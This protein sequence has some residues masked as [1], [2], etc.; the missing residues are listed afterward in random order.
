MRKNILSFDSFQVNEN[1]Y[2]IDTILD[3]INDS[4][5]DSLDF[6]EKKVLENPDIIKKILYQYNIKLNNI[7]DMLSKFGLDS[8]D[9][10]IDTT[11]FIDGEIGVGDYSDLEEKFHEILN[12]LGE[13][14]FINLGVFGK[15]FIK[16][17]NSDD[18]VGRME[19]SNEI[20]DI[21]KV[22]PINLNFIKD[23]R[24]ELVFYDNK[25]DVI[26]E[27][28]R[29]ENEYCFYSQK[30]I[31]KYLNILNSFNLDDSIMNNVNKEIKKLKN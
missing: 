8:D 23:G 18:I 10:Y 6:Y 27:L 22:Y 13:D 28:S 1:K 2:Y 16:Y 21:I 24:T 12:I 29:L 5:I 14:N 9:I 11:F 15:N 25:D 4:G 3:K 20:I 19:Y 17:N 31:D 30:D 7:N 26:I